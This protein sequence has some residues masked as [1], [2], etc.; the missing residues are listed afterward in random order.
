MKFKRW[1]DLSDEEKNIRLR[2]IFGGAAIVFVGVLLLNG[3]I[4]GDA[5][6]TYGIFCGFMSGVLYAVTVILN[7]KVRHATGMENTTCQLVSS[8]FLVFIFLMCTTGIH[9]KIS[10]SEW[11]PVLWIGLLNTGLSCFFY[12]STITKLPMSTV[13][14]FSYLDPVSA[15]ILSTIILKEKLSLGR[16][17]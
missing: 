16:I 17:R 6:K 7:K 9:I 5:T 4:S 1:K 11:I 8:F 13:A 15:V 3:N 10:G 2:R 14:I 12:Y